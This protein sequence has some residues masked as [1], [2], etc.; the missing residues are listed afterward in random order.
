[1]E[2]Q[3]VELERPQLA[4]ERLARLISDRLT[5]VEAELAVLHEQRRRQS[6]EAREVAVRLDGLRK[7]RTADERSLEE[8]REHSRRA[9]LDETEL[10]LRVETA[11]E[12]LRRDLEVEPDT[13]MGAECPPLAEGVSP[14][15]RVRELE[16]EM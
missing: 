14:Q 1:A 7:Q 13:A 2:E 8:V 12:T 4:V 10:G 9:E 3:R 15:A 6:E 16:R 11:V 5:T